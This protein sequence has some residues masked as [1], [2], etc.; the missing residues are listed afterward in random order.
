[1]ENLIL[2]SMGFDVVVSVPVST[3]YRTLR[4]NL[5]SISV[6]FGYSSCS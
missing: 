4:E 5:R 6:I 3:E 2:T 1:M